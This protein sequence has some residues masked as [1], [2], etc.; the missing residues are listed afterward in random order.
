MSYRIGFGYKHPEASNA[1]LYIYD[2]ATGT[3]LIGA[4][5]APT[6]EIYAQLNGARVECGCPPADVGIG[7]W[8]RVRD[9]Y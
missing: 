9:N 8:Q 6:P 4:D 2:D 3:V 7:P 1:G 5:I